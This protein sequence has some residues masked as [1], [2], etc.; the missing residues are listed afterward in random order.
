[1]VCRVQQAGAYRVTKLV[2]VR[3]L[4]LVVCRVLQPAKRVHRAETLR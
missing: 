4:E 3:A 2:M 1:M